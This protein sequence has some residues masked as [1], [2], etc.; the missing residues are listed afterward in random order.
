MN[1]KLRFNEG[2]VGPE[3]SPDDFEIEMRLLAK[4]NPKRAEMMRE[5]AEE[6]RIVDVGVRRFLNGRWQIVWFADENVEWYSLQP[7]LCGQP[8]NSRTPST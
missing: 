8:L 3:P 2:K 4:R 1:K 5:L 7:K 6:G